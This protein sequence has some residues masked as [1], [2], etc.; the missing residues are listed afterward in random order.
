MPQRDLIDIGSAERVPP[1]KQTPCRTPVSTTF[2]LL[3]S[4]TSQPIRVP[5]STQYPTKWATKR[6]DLKER[7]KRLEDKQEKTD[8]QL[9]KLDVQI[10]EL[11]HRVQVLAL[12]SEGYRKIRHRFLEVYR[13]D[14]LNDVDRQG[15]Q[16][17]DEGD[18]A[19]HHGDAVIDAL[20]YTSGERH[21]EGVL[22]NL[23]GLGAAQISY[24]GKYRTS[25]PK[26]MFASLRF[27]ARAGNSDGISTLNA[28]AT[29]RAKGPSNI[30]TDIDNAFK[31][32]VNELSLNP[33][34]S[35]TDGTTSLSK[36]YH[37]FWTAHKR[38]R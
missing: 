7:I 34:K 26:S 19:A 33:D 35:L 20:L 8:A 1:T 25:L 6:H 18:E 31:T 10:A 13:R 16:R 3:F 9:Q 36:A 15:L 11:E 29:W 2:V 22:I 24:L 28:G 27:I 37:A 14:I 21:D 38:P 23:Y 32:F 4:P 5:S 12:V 30:P 17:I